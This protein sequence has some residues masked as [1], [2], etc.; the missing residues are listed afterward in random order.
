VRTRILLI[1][2]N[3]G[4]ACLVEEVLK[5]CVVDYSLRTIDRLEEAF[6]I[7]DADEAD[8]I[9]LDLSLPDSSGLESF[10]RLRAQGP[11]VPIIILTGTSDL[12]TAREAVRNGAQDYLVKGE[13]EGNLLLHAV[14]YAAERHALHQELENLSLRDPL[15]G[16]YNRRGFVLLA[17]QSLR[18]AR[19][20]GRE[21]VL[22]LA[23]V[24]ELKSIN[25]TQ[26]HLAGDQALCAVARAFVAA[27]RESDIIARLA[28]DEFIALAVEAHPPGI[29]SLVGRLRERLREESKATE[30]THGLSVSIGI[31]PFDP[32]GSPTLEE[33]IERAD[34]EMY[35][36]KQNGRRMEATRLN[37]PK[38]GGEKPK[39]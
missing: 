2:D 10:H 14:R 33:L 25:D 34:R 18:L 4:D 29:P 26:G 1:E 28:G 7:L 6:G 13:L 32:K 8:L 15:T 30:V 19:R 12:E 35:R 39:A 27:M 21:S 16:L 38:N 17:Q 3:P 24:D 5:S 22:L 9:L 36:E 31:A 37:D 11:D 23:D 20:N